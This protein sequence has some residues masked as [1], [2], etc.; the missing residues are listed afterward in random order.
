[1]EGVTETKFGTKV[2]WGW[3]WCP[4]V[5]YTHSICTMQ[6]NHMRPHLTMKNMTC[7]TGI[8]DVQ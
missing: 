6:R 5:K 4:N 7:I 2:A 1:M 8:G 3:G